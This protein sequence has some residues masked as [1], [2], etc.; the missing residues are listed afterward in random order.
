[1]RKFMKP[2]FAYLYLAFI[3]SLAIVVITAI[4]FHQRLNKMR[5]EEGYFNTIS[6]W[7]GIITLVAFYFIN[8]EVRIRARYQAELEKKLRELNRSNAELEQ[9]AYIASHDLQ[10]PLRKIRTFTDKLMFRHGEELGED[11]V[12]ML[13]RIEA[14]AQMM[15]ELIQEML[16]FTSLIHREDKMSP[17]DLNEVLTKVMNDFKEQA[18]S[19]GAIIQ[20]DR[21][22]MI[23]G[24]EQQLVLLF[25]SL[26]DNAFKF[27]KPG[28][29]PEI[30]ILYRQVDGSREEDPHLAGKSFYRIILE[31]KGIG[32]SNEFAEKIFM[33]FQ[34][35]HTRQSGY[36]GKGIGLAIAQ[37]IMSNHNGVIMARGLINGGATFIMYFPAP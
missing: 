10:E 34:R 3:A 9:F 13:K 18:Q 4:L 2:G 25:R 19:R 23:T 22:P 1:M 36:R 20:I 5:V 6:I 28:E 37:R 7:A 12:N 14:S 15:Q 30:N 17:A 24:N 35:L 29:P 33:I 11:T 31:D 8:R 27:S 32:F 16:H 21:L 26:I